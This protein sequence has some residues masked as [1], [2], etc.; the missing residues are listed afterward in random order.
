MRLAH[1]DVMCFHRKS[2]SGGVY[3][4]RQ[5]K[6]S[7]SIPPATFRIISEGQR[8]RLQRLSQQRQSASVNSSRGRGRRC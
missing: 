5:R 6:L 1:S 8:R 2:F 3:G 4:V 7:F